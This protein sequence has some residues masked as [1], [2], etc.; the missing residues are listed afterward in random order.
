MARWAFLQAV[1]SAFGVALIY[2][3]FIQ[4]RRAAN[5]AK[6]MVDEGRAATAAA[7][8]NVAITKA[9]M[10]AEL[11]I[12]MM[13][14]ENDRAPEGRTLY[15]TVLNSGATPARAIKMALGEARR[16]PDDP[17][18]GEFIGT[19]K[20]LDFKSISKDGFVVPSLPVSEERVQAALSSGTPIYWRITFAYT[21]IFGT[22]HSADY[23]VS[24]E[25]GQIERK[26][27][28]VVSG[29]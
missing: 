28:G 21:D 12:G 1:L 13:T 27:V 19:P 11:T 18:S 29:G 20:A 8:D 17:I 7:T 10:A 2:F 14:L 25:R 5:Y 26:Q 3:T 22:V 23:L 15:V 6:D 16:R 24:A 4:T 9:Q